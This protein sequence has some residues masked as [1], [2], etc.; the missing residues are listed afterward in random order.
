MID[1]DLTFDTLQSAYSSKIESFMLS[2][3]DQT[4]TDE[5]SVLND[6]IR[7][8][9]LNGGKRIRPLLTIAAN[10]LFSNDVDAIL[11]LACSLEIIH[12]YSLIHDD[13]PSMDNDDLRRGKPTC[14]VKYGEDIAILAGD[15]LNTLAFEILSTHLNS[16][17]DKAILTIIQ[18]ISKHMG[19][20]GLVG[21]Q[22]LDIKSSNK[23]LNL[24]HLNNLHQKKTGA[25]IQL[26]ISS[27][28]YLHQVDPLVIKELE[29]FGS[30]L[31]LLFQI[32]D[33]ILDVVGNKDVLGK[34]PGKDQALNKLTYPGIMSLDDCR[35]IASQ[36]KTKALANLDHLENHYNYDTKALLAILNFTFDRSY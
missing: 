28:A 16:F 2:M 31:G 22:V 20:A 36:E 29:S 13:L 4:I 33:D 5:R 12:T 25:L 17:S 11:P 35:D 6:A 26:A 8:S 21:G 1:T 27:P 24:E 14:H 19:I 30:H 32:I 34:N 10:S 15:T 23:R 18:M 9:L 3:I 7:H